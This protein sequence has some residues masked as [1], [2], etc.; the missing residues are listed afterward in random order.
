MERVSVRLRCCLPVSQTQAHFLFEGEESRLHVQ[1][2]GQERS[3]Q[4]YWVSVIFIF[5]FAF[6]V[7]QPIIHLFIQSVFTQQI[8]TK[9]DCMF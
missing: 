3:T 6:E 1:L 7:R 4:T 8:H 5:L 2:L 9:H